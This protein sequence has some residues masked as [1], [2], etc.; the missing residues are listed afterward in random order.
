MTI[1]V[2]SDETSILRLISYLYKL[3]NVI[4]VEDLNGTAH[5]QHAIWP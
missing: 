1:V 2:E 5:S 3:V 4:Q